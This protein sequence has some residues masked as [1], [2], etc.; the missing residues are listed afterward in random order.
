MLLVRLKVASLVGGIVLFASTAT[1]AQTSTTKA[2]KAEPRL[3]KSTLAFTKCYSDNESPIFP[4]NKLVA[5]CL[6]RHEMALEP[7][8]VEA[9]G[10]YAKADKDGTVFAV[11][12]RNL[13]KD[14]LITRFVVILKNDKAE[15]PQ[16]FPVGPISLVPGEATTLQLSGLQYVPP[17]IKQQEPADFKFAVA[18][19]KGLEIKLR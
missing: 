1:L 19:L 8:L 4:G 10:A 7:E 12:I 17:E 15:S 2:S 6:D 3:E 5:L 13:A 16:Y 18:E 11:R 9:T 14:T